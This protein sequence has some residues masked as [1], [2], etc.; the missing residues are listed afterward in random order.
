MDQFGGTGGGTPWDNTM[1]TA[2]L[3]P[4]QTFAANF[5][6]RGT[7]MTTEELRKAR[8]NRAAEAL[9]MK[10]EQIGIVQEQNDRLAKTVDNVRTLL[11][12]LLSCAN[13]VTAGRD[14]QYNSA[15]EARH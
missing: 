4:N 6:N 3:Q 15:G 2:D 9:R 13:P 1:T 5:R 7:A 11:L 14:G 8:E 10:D 12:R